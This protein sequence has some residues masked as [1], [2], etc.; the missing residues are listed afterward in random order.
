MPRTARNKASSA[1]GDA[2][3]SSAG[4]TSPV[5]AVQRSMAVL[6]SFDADHREWTLAELTKHLGLRRTTVFRLLKT[7]Q[8]ERLVEMNEEGKYVLGPAVFKFAYMW[9]AEAEL[10]RVAMPHLERLTAATEETSVLVVWRGDAPICIAQFLT[11]QYFRPRLAIGR[12]FNDLAN[13]DA[14][15]LVAFGPKERREAALRQ[16]LERLTPFTITDPDRVAEEL[17]RVVRE[18]VAFDLQEQ[19]L[20][21]CAVGVPV[22]DFSGELRASLSVVTPQIR[23]ELTES[24]TIIQALRQVASALSYDLGYRGEFYRP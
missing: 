21:V 14:K 11:P 24:R 13:T 7:L 18:G 6:M 23:F 5:Q 1:N 10:A 22:W 20:G 15:I 8:G 2:E 4:S 9:I 16:P 19:N 12:A 17:D 3:K